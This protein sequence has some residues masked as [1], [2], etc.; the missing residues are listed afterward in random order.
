MQAHLYQKHLEQVCASYDKA[1]QKAKLD[2]IAIFADSPIRIFQDDMDYPFKANFQ[3][4]Y[5]LP[6]TDNPNC[7]VVYK[8][9]QKPKLYFYQPIDFWHKVA[10][11]PDEY[12]TEFFDI[13]YI[14]DISDAKKLF[15]GDLSTTGL[16]A[17][18][19][20]NISDWGFADINP[21]IVVNTINWYRAYKS[22]YEMQCLK[23][24]NKLGVKAHIAARNT[25]Y[26]GGSGLDIHLSYLKA[27]GH[28]ESEL[29]YTN[30]IGLNE[31]SAILHNHS[32]ERSSRAV[33]DRRSFLIDAG[34]Q[35]NGYA[36]DITRTYC[37]QK[38]GVFED[39]IQ[40]MDAMQQQLIEDINLGSSYVDLHIKC[41]YQL[42]KIMASHDIVSGSEEEL[43]SSGI[44]SAFFPHG[45]GHYIGL[46][47]HDVGGLVKNEQGQPNPAPSQHPYLRLTRPIEKGNA[48]T[49]E[50]GF[51]IIDSLLKPFA[52][53]QRI[54][55]TLVDQIKPFGG[56][57][58]E[59]EV[60]VTNQGVENITRK[61]WTELDQ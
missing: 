12:W 50:P 4:K 41:H 11:N 43:V 29:P 24:A 61:L 17:N 9:G 30:I 52:G 33:N 46:Q 38:S 25:Y 8:S 36:S 58:I 55:W 23:E 47:V 45:L 49:I 15:S 32:I 21:E 48:F 22:D 20:S 56:I 27:C 19:G 18:P 26:D 57:R 60:I 53:D 34:A 39:L 51:Y 2:C 16:L 1:M 35:M 42:A 40:S 28:L 10:E 3:F 44:T 31:N 14:R 59:D 6:I 5:W 13:T 54:N 37:Y 7:W